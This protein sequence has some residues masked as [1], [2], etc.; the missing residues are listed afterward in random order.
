MQK[1][2]RRDTKAL[3]Y[4]TLHLLYFT[5]NTL[6]LCPCITIR[7]FYCYITFFHECLLCVEYYVF[8]FFIWSSS[9][10]FYW[11]LFSFCHTVMRTDVS[12]RFLHC[13]FLLVHKKQRDTSFPRE[14]AK[15]KTNL[16]PIPYDN[17]ASSSSSSSSRRELLCYLHHERWRRN[18]AKTCTVKLLVVVRI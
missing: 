9:S 2:I 13:I 3:R 8:P 15:E 4:I 18:I 17:S 7:L 10:C 14:A 11:S 5:I 6:L 1:G 16:Q 12:C